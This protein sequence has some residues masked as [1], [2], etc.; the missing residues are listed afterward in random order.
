MRPPHDLPALAERLDDVA[1]GEA[2]G[3]GNEN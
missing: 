2:G 3:A 1:A